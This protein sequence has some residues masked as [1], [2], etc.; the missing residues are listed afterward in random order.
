M[1]ILCK[2]CGG[3]LKKKTLSSGNAIGI[4][5]AIIFLVVGILICCTVVGAIIGIPI[6]ICSLFVG[7]KRK[8]C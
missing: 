2:I 5:L 7:G 6:I 3:N 1:G 8:K 4:I